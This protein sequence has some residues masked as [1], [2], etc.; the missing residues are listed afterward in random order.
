MKNL[1]KDSHLDIVVVF[2]RNSN[3]GYVLPAFKENERRLNFEGHE[4]F[5]QSAKNFLKAFHQMDG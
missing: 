4:R 5:Q 1:W 3:W 2:A